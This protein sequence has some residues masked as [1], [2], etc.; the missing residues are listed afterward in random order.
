M[1]RY[2]NASEIATMNTFQI[3]DYS[4]GEQMG[5]KDSRALDRAVNQPQEVILTV[6]FIQ[7]LRKK[8]QF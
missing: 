8:Q 2:L 6:S 5:V 4:P 7:V 1:V 3:M